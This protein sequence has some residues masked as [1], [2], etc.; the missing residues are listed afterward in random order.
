MQKELM[1]VCSS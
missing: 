1:H